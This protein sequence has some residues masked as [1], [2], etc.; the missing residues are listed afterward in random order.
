MLRCVMRPSTSLRPA[1]LAG[2]L[3]VLFAGAFAPARGLAQAA[4]RAAAPH[5]PEGVTP[6]RI[7][8]ER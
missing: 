5:L 6:D 4:P 1:V 7:G 2:P 3:L 8:S